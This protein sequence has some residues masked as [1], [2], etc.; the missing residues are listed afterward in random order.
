[1][2]DGGYMLPEY[3]VAYVKHVRFFQDL[4]KPGRLTDLIVSACEYMIYNQED[5]SDLLFY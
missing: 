5:K 3:G 2:M 4:S 1:M